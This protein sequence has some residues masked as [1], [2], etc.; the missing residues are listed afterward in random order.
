MQPEDIYF[1]GTVPEAI[2]LCQRGNLALVIFL[3]SKCIAFL[4]PEQV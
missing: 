1:K 3:L 4:C 2:D